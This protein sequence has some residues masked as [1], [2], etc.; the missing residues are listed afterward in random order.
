MTAEAIVDKV[1][2]LLALAESTS[3]NE[4]AVA[5]AAA[6]RL[7]EKHRL[8]EAMLADHDE[9]PDVDDVQMHD[10]CL[11]KGA[12]FAQWKIDLACITAEHNCCR[13]AAVETGSSHTTLHLIGTAADAAVS[14][15]LYR[16]LCVE[17]A[18]LVT[19]SKLKGAV[20]KAAFRV[21]AVFTIEEQLGAAVKSARARARA[22]AREAAVTSA[23]TLYQDATALAKARDT[24]ADQLLDELSDGEATEVGKH[25]EDFDAAAFLIGMTSAKSIDMTAHQRKLDS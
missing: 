24:A 2:K 23:L 14:T 10:D 3:I 11:D 9:A 5:A 21:G 1:R 25:D 4:S 15:A 8:T 7:I 17:I 13:V 6:Q 16:W 18:R 12:R 19:A 22:Q 20:D